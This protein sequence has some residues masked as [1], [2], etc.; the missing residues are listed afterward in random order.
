M[1]NVYDKAIVSVL[2]IALNFTEGL[3]AP[4]GGKSKSAEA[5]EHALTVFEQFLQPG[6]AAAL[7]QIAAA[8][9]TLGEQAESTSEYQKAKECF[10]KAAQYFAKAAET[11]CREAEYNVGLTF[12][13]LKQYDKSAIYY[14]KCINNCCESEPDLALKAAINL[15]ILVMEKK[16][17]QDADEIVEWVNLCKKY[18]KN[19]KAAE[20]LQTS[21]VILTDINS[22]PKTEKTNNTVETEAVITP[23]SAT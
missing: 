17:P 14:R 12:N 8:Y 19:P 2:L 16:V 22:L 5:L 1:W 11:G 20:L 21:V 6:S 15:S 3:A 10:L 7:N 23:S 18:N 4:S 13:K 9:F